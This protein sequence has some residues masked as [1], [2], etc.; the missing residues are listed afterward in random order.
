MPLA[1][2]EWNL[3][4]GANGILPGADFTFGSRGSG[5][6]LL[7]PYEITYPDAEVGDTPMPRTDAIR[8]GQDFRAAAV[9]T[10]EIGVDTV[11]AAT[12]QLGRHGK[13]LDAL[14]AGAQAWD[15]EAVRRR[16]GVPAVL[17]TVQGGRA[18]RFYGRPRKWAPAGS[19]LTRQGYTPVVANFACV[20]TV[21][22]DDVQQSKIVRLQPPDH[23][24]LVGPL[25]T[26]ITMTGESSS[27]LPGGL[28][29]GGT[30]PTWPVI[31]IYGPISQPQCV[32]I[33]RAIDDL[34]PSKGRRP[35]WTVGLDLG[36]GEGET[37]KIDTRPW[38][39]TILR[40]GEAS[41]AG[42]VTWGTPLMEDMRLPVGRQDMTLRG[43]DDTGTARMVVAWRDAYA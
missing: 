28:I 20:D 15:G 36:L 9:I 5:Y 38:A 2:G 19:R 27:V 25:K 41:V 18:R 37:V 17:R 30:R 40:N 35:G 8:L 14:S 13:N 43:V 11:D 33:D 39:R 7:E 3:S 24:G 12:T 16:F 23:R 22:Y 6:Y 34:D 26:P 21:A 31:T 29:I 10:F 32:L 4:Y 42:R 1:E